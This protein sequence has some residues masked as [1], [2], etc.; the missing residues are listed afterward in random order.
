MTVMNKAT[1]TVE[2]DESDLREWDDHYSPATFEVMQDGADSIS[3][4][5]AQMYEAPWLTMQFLSA[6]SVHFGTTDIDV[7][8]GISVPG[9]ETCDYGSLYGHQ[10][11][12]RNIT[13][14]NPFQVTP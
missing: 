9:C 13:Q 2:W 1:I 6:L 7:I 3:F 14:N 8:G 11:V 4:D 10:I 12:I 5:W